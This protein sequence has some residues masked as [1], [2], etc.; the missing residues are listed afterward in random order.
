MTDHVFTI[1]HLFCGVG[2]GAL[3]SANARVAI[4]AHSA[5]FR[6]LGGVDI[7]RPSCQD[8]GHLIG[9]PATE[10]DLSTMQPAD[11]LAAWGD[12]APH[13]VLLSPPCK[14]FSGLLSKKMSKSDRY[15]KLNKLVLD[16]LFLICSTWKQP[17]AIIFLENVPRITSRGKPLLSKAR[18][19]LRAHGYRVTED[20]Y[21]DCGE[22]GGLAQHRKRF[23]L[24]ARCERRVPHFIYE[25]GKLRVRACGEVLGPMPIPGDEESG[26]PLH[27]LPNISWL[28]WVRL[29]LIPPGGDWRDL[30]GVLS[31]GQKRREVHR[32]HHV[33]KWEDPAATVAGSG[34]NGVNNVAD[35]RPFALPAENPG[36]H[37][38][39]YKVNDWNEPAG[40][41]IGAIQPG[42]GGPAVADPRLAEAVS[43]GQTAA[44]AA[45]Y[46]GRPGLLGVLDWNRPAKTLT[47][48]MRVHSSNAPAAV[49]DPRIELPDNPNRHRTKYRVTPWDEPVGTINSKIH[50]GSSAPSVADP[51]WGGG[52]GSGKFGVLPW[53]EPSGAVTG[54]ARPSTGKFAVAD[55]RPPRDPGQ[56][57]HRFRI[58]RWDEPAGT[59]TS[60]MHPSNGGGAVADPRVDSALAIDVGLGCQPWERSGF[61]G[62]LSW[63]EAADTI[64]GAMQI[65]NGRAA[66][67]DPRD[68]PIRPVP[69]GLIP[70]DPKKPPGF[71]PVIIAAD[72]TWHRPLT[73]LELA[74]LQGF[75]TIF[76]GKPLKLVGTSSSAWRERIGNAIPPPAAQAIASEMLLAL[77][78]AQLD[79]RQLRL[80]QVWV[81]DQVDDERGPYIHSTWEGAYAA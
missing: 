3:G 41:V 10:A 49:A 32:R 63:Q 11:L 12:T 42:S 34:S 40:A 62:V 57:G 35:P 43:M 50:P 58:A 78:A 80:D 33:A 53:E 73:T 7:D 25:P 71:T 61:Y 13:M 23:F 36:R 74:A 22:L 81:K 45:S 77:L 38:N 26:G 28:N 24:V 64:T 31:D 8:F 39:K 75:P 9:T 79:H 67:A 37:W 55:P 30:P 18:Q 4:G 72:G 46:K 54:N 66:V 5:R 16:G 56:F 21:H 2:G 70:S 6:T 69:E 52:V 68:L 29:A 44:G 51:R 20:A 76:K 65:D 60:G 19:L 14:G 17:P 48:E 1:G 47:G 59:V 27:R 15:Q